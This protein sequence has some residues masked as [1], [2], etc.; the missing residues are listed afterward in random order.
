MTLKVYDYSHCH[1]LFDVNF[2]RIILLS[3]SNFAC[4]WTLLIPIIII[5]NAWNS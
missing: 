4:G 2:N 5:N 3:R 1:K